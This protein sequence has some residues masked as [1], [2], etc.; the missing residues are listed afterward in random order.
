M[1]LCMVSYSAEVYVVK[2]ENV[3]MRAKPKK[4]GKKLG[5]LRQGEVLLVDTVINGWATCRNDAGETFYVAL[6]HIQKKEELKAEKKAE[7]D[8]KYGVPPTEVI[9]HR[10]RK[11]LGFLG[12]HPKI[13]SRESIFTLAFYLPIGFI[14]FLAVLNFILKFF[15][16]ESTLSTVNL[17]ILFLCMTLMSLLEMICIISHDGDP[18]W[19]CD[20]D[21][22]LF[23]I[24]FW[25][26]M[27]IILAGFQ[28]IVLYVYNTTVFNVASDIS[29]TDHLGPLSTYVC[30][31]LYLLFYLFLTSLQ[32]YVAGLFLLCQ[33]V[34]LVLMYIGSTNKNVFGLIKFGFISFVYLLMA[35]STFLLIIM[36]IAHLFYLA[37]T[38]SFWWYIGIG[39][40]ILLLIGGALGGGGP[41]VTLYYDRSGNFKGGIIHPNN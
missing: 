10:V 28:A 1:L 19:F 38:V 23:T 36:I 17:F 40:L 27:M 24:I 3:V 37:S 35:V 9:Q 16:S 6:D 33:L 8:K 20:V 39:I 15:V 18:A 2:S 12:I 30:S 11:V 25:L 32:P 21:H 7:K 29:L 41:T 13:K 26:V 5:N 14:G 34:H 22:S 31:L 4:G